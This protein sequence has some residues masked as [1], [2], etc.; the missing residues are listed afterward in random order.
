M[1]GVLAKLTEVPKKQKQRRP[2]AKRRPP[3][4]QHEAQPLEPRWRALIELLER[5]RVTTDESMACIC[6]GRIERSCL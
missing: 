1:R 5:F 3:S 6:S 4:A 2:R